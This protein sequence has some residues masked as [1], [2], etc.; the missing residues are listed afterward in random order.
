MFQYDRPVELD[1]SGTLQKQTIKFT[2]L[3][4][5]WAVSLEKYYQHNQ[6]LPT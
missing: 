5:N 4:K 6:I 3:L 1:F 2:P